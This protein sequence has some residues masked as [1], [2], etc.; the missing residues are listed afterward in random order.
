MKGLALVHLFLFFELFLKLGVGLLKV[1]EIVVEE[2]HFSHSLH[3]Q[4][5]ELSLKIYVLL[6]LL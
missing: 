6:L 4:L 5:V 1:V 3:L 2:P